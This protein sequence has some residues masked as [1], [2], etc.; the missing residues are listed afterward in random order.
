MLSR[1]EASCWRRSASSSARA[2]GRDFGAQARHSRGQF[3]FLIQKAAEFLFNG[4]AAFLLAFL[5]GLFERGQKL[6][7]RELIGGQPQS[8]FKL[9]ATADQ[10]ALLV[11]QGGQAQ[12]VLS[13]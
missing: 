4:H 11:A 10:R 7:Q 5:L 13:V 9:T 12:K 2:Q 1:S 6:F 8:V 3:L